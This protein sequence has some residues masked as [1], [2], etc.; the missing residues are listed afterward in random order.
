MAECAGGYG[1][2]TQILGLSKV[3]QMAVPIV[4]Q[5]VV[6]WF[7]LHTVLELAVIW[8]CDRLLQIC[9]QCIYVGLAAG[10]LLLTTNHL[11]DVGQPEA[12]Y[13]AY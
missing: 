4:D 1:C 6:C 13:F 11:H 2:R 7:Y 10:S 12:V 5:N 3:D 9:T 8:I